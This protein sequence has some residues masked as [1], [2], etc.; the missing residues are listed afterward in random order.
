MHL[1]PNLTIP[2]TEP[3]SGTQK[4]RKEEL[5]KEQRKKAPGAFLGHGTHV[6]LFT[7]CPCLSPG[8]EDLGVK[9]L[10]TATFS[11]LMPSLLH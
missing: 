10:C 8:T 6:A 4:D 11:N 2:C 1:P 3:V 7:A 9:T 5:K